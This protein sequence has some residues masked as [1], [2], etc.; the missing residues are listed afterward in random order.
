[1]GLSHVPSSIYS[2]LI[3]FSCST[4]AIWILG[5]GA[6]GKVV[7]C[8]P[9][10][11]ICIKGLKTSLAEGLTLCC[12]WG[13]YLLLLGRLFQRFFGDYHVLSLYLPL[14]IYDRL[15]YRVFPGLY[16]SLQTVVWDFPL[17]LWAKLLNSWPGNWRAFGPFYSE[18]NEKIAVGSLPFETDIPYLT[19]KG[20]RGV[21]NM[22]REYDGPVHLYKRHDIRHIHLR[23]PDLMEP[24]L[25]DLVEGVKFIK[26]LEEQG[27]G[28]VFIHCKG[29]RGRA[30]SM[31]LCYLL[32]QG[33]DIPS[34]MSLIKAKRYVAAG[35]I[36]KSAV[37]REFSRLYAS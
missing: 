22:T 12:V 17:L 25:E 2:S 16:L 35:V 13:G 37:V 8:L 15:L 7:A 32:S 4:F 30:V 5:G 33:M 26:A 14:P 10:S 3:G 1:M 20:V 9:F 19:G 36:A 31:A 6:F 23:T 11:L 34:A 29:G 28:K 27:G 24:R 21:I 18:I